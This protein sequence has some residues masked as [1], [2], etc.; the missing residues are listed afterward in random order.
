MR[1]AADAPVPG[2][3]I[4]PDAAERTVRVSNSPM[5]TDP[6]SLGLRD[7]IASAAAGN[8]E[9][10]D[11]LF[12]RNMALLEA[13]VRVRAGAAVRAR[14]SI[15]D[16]VQSVCREAVAD[17]DRFEFRGEKE[18][19]NWLFLKAGCRVLKKARFHRAERRDVAREAQAPALDP[20]ETA[21]LHEAYACFITPSQCA[22]ARAEVAAV[23]AMI[24]SLPDAQRDAVTMTRLLGMSYAEAAAEMGLSESAVRGLVA[25]GLARVAA[26][27][28]RARGETAR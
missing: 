20:D 11:A 10:I 16:I 23:E 8:A 14:E 15:R 24:A 7:T 28:A 27:R 22:D 1:R 18:F 9:A 21:T 5:P 6:S 12:A 19:R 25:R 26:L 2:D 13:F 17:L 4:R 3:T